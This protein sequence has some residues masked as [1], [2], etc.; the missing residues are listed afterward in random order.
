MS[1]GSVVVLLFLPVLPGRRYLSCCVG[2][3][4]LAL[5]NIYLI[6]GPRKSGGFNHLYFLESCI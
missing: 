3:F 4:L 2:R 1:P 5:F 6:L